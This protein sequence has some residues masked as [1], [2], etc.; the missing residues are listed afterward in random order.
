MSD[1]VHLEWIDATA[2]RFSAN[3]RVCPELG[4]TISRWSQSHFLTSSAGRSTSS[5]VTELHQAGQR[6]AELLRQI[7]GHDETTISQ[8]HFATTGEQALQEML[9]AARE[10][11]LAQANASSEPLKCLSVVGSD[12]G[13]GVIGRMASGRADRHAPGWPL[14]AG[15]DHV[16]WR[17]MARR[18]DGNTA[19]VLIS[20][21]DWHE[22]AVRAEAE[23]LTAIRAACD[24]HGAAL[25]IDHRQLAPMGG[26][27]FWVQDSM[28]EISADAVMMSAGL[29]GGID[30]VVVVSSSSLVDAIS[31]VPV[32]QSSI[33][34]RVMVACIIEESLKGWL[35]GDLLVIDTEDFAV[36]LA[37]RLSG[38]ESIRDLHVTGRIIGIEMDVPAEDWIA[39]AQRCHLKVNPA[40][41]FAVGLQPP[42]IISET[43]AS[44]LIDRI[45][46]VFDAIS[47]IETDQELPE[48]QA[49]S[50]APLIEDTEAET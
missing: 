25:V 21:I 11:K 46:T 14:V 16:P 36:N 7:T 9:V 17:D 12:H 37:S 47:A 34:G 19:M 33:A 30:S 8:C 15:F 29:C 18:I 23:Y 27:F 26:G 3:G 10:S 39:V 48:E 49:D 24:E 4:E 32:D 20:P 43:E 31:D 41:E 50:K 2:G 22:M 44:D 38:Y 42:L 28:T 6:V 45:G 5:D 40:G 1:S 13:G 35:S